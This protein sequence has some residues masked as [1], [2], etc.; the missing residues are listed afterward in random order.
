MSADLSAYLDGELDPARAAEVQRYLEESEDARRVLAELTTISDGLRLLPR[1]ATS[2]EFTAT[3]RR[4]VEQRLHP[5]RPATVRSLRLFF[6]LGAVAAA[7]IGGVWIGWRVWAPVPAREPL[8]A[9][10]VAAMKE[11]KQQPAPAVRSEV[12]A[13]PKVAEV[14]RTEMKP[15]ETPIAA[16]DLPVVV[17]TAP[18]VAESAQG[19]EIDATI[20]A[21]L[22]LT[23][24][25]ETEYAVASALLTQWT[26]QGA[27]QCVSA[28]GARQQVYLMSAAEFPGRMELLGDALG[29]AGSFEAA[30]GVN[31][32]LRPADATSAGAT[33]VA[34]EMPAEAAPM[35][36]RKEEPKKAQPAPAAAPPAGARG[37][38]AAGRAAAREIAERQHE[39]FLDRDGR[40]PARPDLE[41]RHNAIVAKR[42]QSAPAPAAATSQATGTSGPPQTVKIVLRPPAAASQPTTAP[43]TEK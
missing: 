7:L 30:R 42:A 23:P 17:A 14:L 27:V 12:P 20:G 9:Q 21:N 4:E 15:V 34:P 2:P 19:P 33:P 36:A 43:A 1:V 26:A 13:A 28:T 39:S 5:Q 3:L 41:A 35:Q 10:R 16:S 6:G 38:S 18:P 25:G 32:A 29:A 11:P 31:A 37:E 24:A 8:L 22:V 40:L